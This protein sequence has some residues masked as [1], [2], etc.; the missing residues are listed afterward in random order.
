MGCNCGAA[1][2]VVVHES[3][4]PDGTVKRYL[5]EVEARRDVAAHGGEY[6]QVTQTAR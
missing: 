5:T 1:R 2:K 3:H 6:E 4:R